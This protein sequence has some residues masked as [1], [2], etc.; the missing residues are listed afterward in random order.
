MTITHAMVLAAGLG[1][2][3]RPL[4]HTTPKPLV[5][6]AG[7]ALI[8]WAL[9]GLA[10]AGIS[11]A[12]VNLHHLGAQIEAH[13]KDRVQPAITF[14]SEDPV[15]ET[16][17]GVQN[18]LAHLGAAPF[19]VLNSDG[20]WIDDGASAL[21]H[22]SAVWDDAHMDGLLLLHDPKTAFGYDGAGDFTV[23]GKGRVKRR[24]DGDTD[25]LVFTGVQILHPRLFANA[26]GGAYSL[27]VLYDQ[28]LAAGRLF[29]LTHPGEWHHVGT[30]DTLER[31]DQHLRH[32]GMGV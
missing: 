27:N 22:M 24:Q 20:L 6:V 11:Q 14:V 15:L 9:D 7:K 12:V 17:G 31:S 16:G 18:A 5:P 2:R 25:A 10:H 26:P 4:T 3:M 21:S 28:A 29:G 30:M 8:D 32:K 19:F 1:T 13:L 23:D